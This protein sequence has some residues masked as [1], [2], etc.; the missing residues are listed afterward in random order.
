MNNIYD[1]SNR[2]YAM[3]NASERISRLDSLE[4]S[5]EE[6][7]KEIE[8][9]CNSNETIASLYNNGFD[10]I[11]LDEYTEYY[12]KRIDFN[13]NLE[14]LKNKIRRELIMT[15]PDWDKDAIENEI[16]YEINT[17]F[18]DNFGSYTFVDGNNTITLVVKNNL[19]LSNFDR[20]SFTFIVLILLI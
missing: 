2:R 7:N 19:F 12:N 6:I 15:H 13:I 17:I 20:N 9:L 8:N 11:D 5:E 18:T 4:L 1:V 3:V 16:Y 14:I 10:L